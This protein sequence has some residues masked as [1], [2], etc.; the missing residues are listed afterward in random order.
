MTRHESRS[1]RRAGIRDGDALLAIGSI[2]VTRWRTDSRVKPLSRFFQHPAGTPID[3]TIERDG[4][5]YD[6]HLKLRTFIRTPSEKTR[7]KSGKQRGRIRWRPLI[8]L[9][10]AALALHLFCRRQTHHWTRAW[11]GWNDLDAGRMERR[12]RD[13]PRESRR[14]NRSSPMTPFARPA[15]DRQEYRNGDAEECENGDQAEAESHSRPH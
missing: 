9:I 1:A 8:V 2:D 4:K 7:T 14:A 13:R 6:F 15:S 12:E 11:G 10:P 5:R 3:L